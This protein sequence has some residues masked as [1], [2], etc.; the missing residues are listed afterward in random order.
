MTEIAARKG[1]GGRS[2]NNPCDDPRRPVLLTSV[3]RSLTL[4][5]MADDRVPGNGEKKAV[6]YE[7]LVCGKT[8]I[9]THPP[10]CHGVPMER[11]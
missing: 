9:A 6:T 8:R 3:V 1:T 4:S 10:I 5:S 2:G 7:C 11:A